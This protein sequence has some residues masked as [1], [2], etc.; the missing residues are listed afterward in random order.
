MLEP[1]MTADE[2]LARNKA[3]KDATDATLKAHLPEVILDATITEQSDIGSRSSLP[4]TD[5]EISFD[6]G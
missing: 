5:A 1:L 3:Y 6:I 4:I 2:K